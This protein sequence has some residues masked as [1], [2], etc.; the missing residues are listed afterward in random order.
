VDDLVRRY[1]DL[2]LVVVGFLL[3]AV[4]ALTDR[5]V[6]LLATGSCLMLVGV[7]AKR[8]EGPLKLG[9]SG[10]ETV[11]RGRAEE[12][13]VRELDG[14]RNDAVETGLDPEGPPRMQPGGQRPV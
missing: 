6:I 14:G 3:L 2:L 11:L 12:T 1:G 4:A 8:M 5:N 9:P 13:T 7:F 10:L